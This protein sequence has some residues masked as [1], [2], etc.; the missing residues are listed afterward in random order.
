MK[1]ITLAQAVFAKRCPEPVDISELSSGLLQAAYIK[2][3]EKGRR[4]SFSVSVSEV[5]LIDKKGFEA[6]LLLL[7]C[8]A[9]KIFVYSHRGKIAIKA[10]AAELDA[11]RPL[12][13]VLKI[14]AFKELKTNTSILIIPATKTEK[15]PIKECDVSDYI[16]DPFSP[17][18]VFLS[19]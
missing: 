10:R 13:D 9:E 3:L 14:T 15:K 6:L 11:C 8:S 7:C 19:E 2:L 1:K 17:V 12:I 4:F 18:N 16:I 5:F